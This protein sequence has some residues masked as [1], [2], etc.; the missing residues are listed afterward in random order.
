MVLGP[1]NGGLPWP[2]GFGHVRRQEREWLGYVR[3]AYKLFPGYR[4]T[5]KY[6]AAI[7]VGSRATQQQISS[8]YRQKCVYIPENGI[9]P[10]RFRTAAGKPDAPPVRVAFVGRLVPYKGADILIEAAAPLVR[11]GAV[12][13][14]LIGDGP[15]KPALVE[16]ARREKILSGIRFTGALPHPEVA[17]RL[18]SMHVLGFPSIREFGGAVV[19]ESMALGVVPMVV[20]Y[21]GP[22]ELV[23][24]STGF[25]VPIGSRPELVHRFRELL[26]QVVQDPGRLEPIREKA[27]RYVLQEF[28]WEAKAR[29]VLEVYEWALEKRSRKPDFAA[30]CRERP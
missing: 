11:Q 23:T 3:D 16:L 6:A 8:E 13:V 7:I 29:K 26:T 9:D 27:R 30:I 20:D 2:R 19:L 28:T 21:G 12:Q 10:A 4:S 24:D 5:R 17:R 14:E 25:R 22:G 1:L 18:A 15:Q